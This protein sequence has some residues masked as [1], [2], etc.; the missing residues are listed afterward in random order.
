MPEPVDDSRFFEVYDGHVSEVDQMTRAP[1]PAPDDED[2]STPAEL[3]E[4]RA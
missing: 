2:R 1:S 4:D 3:E